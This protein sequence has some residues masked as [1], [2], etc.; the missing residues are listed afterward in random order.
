MLLTGVAGLV[1]PQVGQALSGS[2]A[3]LIAV[4][5]FAVSLSFDVAAAM[6]ALSYLALL[7]AVV[8]PNAGAILAA[9]STMLLI[10]A[11]VVFASGL[12][13]EIALPAIIDAVVQLV[14]LPVVANAVARHASQTPPTRDDG[15]SGCNGRRG[16][17]ADARQPGQARDDAGSACTG[18]RGANADARQ[19]GQARDDGRSACTGTATSDGTG[20]GLAADRPQWGGGRPGIITTACTISVDPS[21]TSGPPPG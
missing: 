13:A 20:R 16:A 14:T 5:M 21:Q 10:A 19:P 9:P 15:R 11:A 4:L 1:A 8:G 17:N 3:I 7:L 18:R 6:D 12:P 2:V